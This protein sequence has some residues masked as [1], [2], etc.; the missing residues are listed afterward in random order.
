M[1]INAILPVVEA[2]LST[3]SRDAPFLAAARIFGTGKTRMLVV[4]DGEGQAVG[5]LTRTDAMRH[6]G[7]NANPL[8]A[9]VAELMTSK[10]T[11]ARLADDL[12][13]TWQMMTRLRLNHLPILDAEGRP[14]GI[15]TT[16]DALKALLETE[17]YE[18]HL[19]A[20]YVAGIGYQ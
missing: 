17:R 8:I 16:D 3:I 7:D 13:D 15:L 11:I 6:V 4:C 1:W 12:L 18:E 5:V 9:C 2:R 20:D 14:I 19:L 10:L